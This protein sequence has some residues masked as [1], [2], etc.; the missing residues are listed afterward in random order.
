MKV[1]GNVYDIVESYMKCKNKHLKSFKDDKE[2]N[3]DE[4]RDIDEEK[5]NNYNNK[6]LGEFPIHQLLQ[7]LS[8]NDLLRDIDAVSLYPIAKSDEKSIHPKIGICYVY[9]TD[10][11]NKLVEKLNI[12]TLTQG[13]AI[14]KYKY[15][16]L[17]NLIVQHIPIKERKKKIEINRMRSGYIVDV[18][19][20]VE[21]QE[22]VK[23]GGK[24]V[25]I[26]ESVI[27]REN[28]ELSPFKNDIDKVFELRQKYKDESI[29]VMHLLVKLILNSLYGD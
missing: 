14:S 15:Y 20:S 18:L 8:L 3:F 25:Q 7:Q 28:F 1:D 26:Y 6:K 9:T 27:Y 29:D 21:I 10:M 19:T 5:L 16:S 11:I 2:S 17:K 23:I 24:A 4:Y 22:I 12:Q 13:S